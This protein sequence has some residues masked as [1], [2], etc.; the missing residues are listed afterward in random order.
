MPRRSIPADPSIGERIRAR[1]LLRRWS[2]RHAA[3]RAGIAHTTW[4][5][6]ERGELRTDRYM[7]ADLAAALECSV[8]DLTGQPRVPADRALENAHARMVGVWRALVEIAP[9]EPSTRPVQP[10][11]TLAQRVELV[12][13]RR[14]AGDY[15]AV[16]LLLPDLLAD[17]HAAAVGPAPGDA[18]RLL[19]DALHSTMLTVRH[20][21]YVVEPTLAAERCRQFAERL[22]EPVA[23][24][25]ADW[26]R[27]HAAC[28]TASYGRALTLTTRTIDTLTPNLAEPTAHEVLGMLHLTSA[29]AVLADRDVAVARGHLAEAG[30]L[31]DLVG[32]TT[33]W[34]MLFGPANVGVWRMQVE[35]DAGEPGRAV[36][37]SRGIDAAALSTARRGSYHVEY[38]RALTDAGQD[39]DAVH[40]LLVAERTAPQL[41][42]SWLVAQETARYLLTRARLNAGGSQLRGLCER[43]GVAD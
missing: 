30:R 3:S 26:M 19:V 22:D 6:I 9:D 37:I 41:V 33:S 1:R 13:A 36:E 27:A 17:L 31:A 24:A 18:L 4:S 35:I 2:V 7:I 12:A 39:R 40:Q 32:E 34:S 15:A 25:V 42:R 28:A 5:R 14:L 43:L 8:S 38:A 23:L 21:G 10:V 11:A 16:A 29:V 20:L